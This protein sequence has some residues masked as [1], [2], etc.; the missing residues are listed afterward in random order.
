M[1]K[2]TYLQLCVKTYLWKN[3]ITLREFSKIIG[4]HHSNLGRF[5]N[6]ASITMESYI[7]ILNWL[8]SSVKEKNNES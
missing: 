7:K 2:Q 6:G 4:I 3:E 5:L 1:S 8:N